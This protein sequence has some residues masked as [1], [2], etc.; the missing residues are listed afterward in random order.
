M[1]SGLFYFVVLPGGG[2]I[3]LSSSVALCLF[4]G[5]MH[6][7][8]EL[9]YAPTLRFFEIKLFRVSAGLEKA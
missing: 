5:F 2:I 8:L 9:I 3:L 7:G 6:R 1:R 4:A